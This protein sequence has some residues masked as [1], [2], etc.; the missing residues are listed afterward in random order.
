MAA[1]LD[2]LQEQVEALA[3]RLDILAAVRQ[4]MAATLQQQPGSTQEPA[5]GPTV[6]PHIQHIADFAA[7]YD[8]L[9][10]AE[11]AQ[12]LFDR[13]IYRARDRHTGEAKPVNRGTLQKW[14]EQARTAG[15]L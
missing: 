14:L 4:P 3:A 6:A 1:R 2:A 8:K 9:S 10:L 7:T 11:L 12:L 5:P 15:L 13:G